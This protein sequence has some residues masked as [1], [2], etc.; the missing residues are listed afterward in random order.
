MTT[1]LVTGAGGFVGSHVVEQLLART[2]WHVVGV[3]S[4]R[5]GGEFVKLLD[6]CE[7]D[8]S[9]VAAFVHDLRVPFTARNYRDL[10]NVDYVVNIA[11]RSHVTES[12]HEPADFILNNV[13]LATTVLELCRHVEPRRFVHMSTD[14]VH[15][16][17]HHGS[18]VEHR[19]SSP[20][21]ASKAA[22]ADLIW[23]Y[24]R[25]FGVPSTIVASANMFGERQMSTAYVPLVMRAL[26]TGST[27]YV[28]HVD[29]AP[30][31]RCYTYVRNVAGRIL[32]ELVRDEPS[33][34]GDDAVRY[35]SLRGQRRVD[36][37]TLAQ[38]IADLAGLPLTWTA[39]D[40]TRRRPGYDPTYHDIGDDWDAAVDFDDGLARTV[41]WHLA[42]EV[43]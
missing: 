22:Q 17:G 24:A 6:A 14:E 39:T 30:G 28:D 1:V 11:S 36:N 9:R 41:R 42:Q 13:Q 12:V 16:P 29:G 18:A 7:H 43:P 5:Q 33:Y 40:A 8:T 23:A 34:V 21:A 37:L 25:T 4:F 10:A 35:V 26:R 2:D 32:T 38:T 3:D 31:E 20:Y 19:P 27:L 15:G